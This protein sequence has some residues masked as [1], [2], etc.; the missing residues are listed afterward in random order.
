MEASP[1]RIPGKYPV[2]ETIYAHQPRF[3]P[4]DP[5]FRHFTE[6]F[7]KRPLTNEEQLTFKNKEPLPH[8]LR[9]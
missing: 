3:D 1:K 8:K 9:L 6:Q 7:D 4:L 5:L 2:I